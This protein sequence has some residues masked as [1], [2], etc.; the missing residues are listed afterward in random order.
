LEFEKAL[1]L[2]KEIS[3]FNK[4]NL[5]E[6]KFLATLDCNRLTFPKSRTIITQGQV[7]SSLFIL[8]EGSLKVVREPHSKVTLA[9]LKPGDVFG[10]VSF[11]EHRPRTTSVIALEESTVLKMDGQ[12]IQRLNPALLNKIKDQLIDL[13]LQRLDAMNK[14]MAGGD[15]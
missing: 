1:A 15:S 10:E 7:E 6:K 13:L 8:L 11:I 3:F 9:V 2:I 5:E 14:R 12:M 4:L